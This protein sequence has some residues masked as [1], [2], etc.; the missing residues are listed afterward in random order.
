MRSAL[1]RAAATLGTGLLVMSVATVPA[2][3]EPATLSGIV[4]A[5]DTGLPV[6][7]CVN[8]YDTQY[9]WIESQCTDES[10]RWVTTSTESGAVYKVEIASNDQGYKSEWAVDTDMYEMA[11]EYIAPATVPGVLAAYGTP[12]LSG[13]IT[14]DVTGEPLDGCVTAYR[15]ETAEW[16]G[17]AC[18]GS[19]AAG[20]WKLYD[21]EQGAA[22]RVEVGAW[23]GVH[24]GEWA[25]DAT[26]FDEAVDIVVP[27]VVDTGLKAGARITGTLLGTDGSA[28]VDEPVRVDSADGTNA[29]S[30]TWT[31]QDGTWS[32]SVAPGDYVVSF[33]GTQTTQYAVGALSREDA[34]VFSVAAG[35][36]ADAS[37]RLLPAAS[38]QGVIT[39]AV[40][41]SP[42]G[43]ACV[44]VIE[45]PVRDTPESV[46]EACTD[47][48]GAYSAR[49]SNSGQFIARVEDPQGRFAFEYTGDAA[50]PE[51]AAP[52]EV[53]AGTPTT[54]DAA[55]GLGASISGLA[56]DGKTDVPIDGAC[57][58]PY[59][60]NDGGYA[61]GAVTEC[62][63]TDGRWTVKGLPA[64]GYAL[65]LSTGDK[66]PYV[67]GTWAFKATSQATAELVDVRAGQELAVRNVK[68]APGGVL[69][70]RVTDQFGRPA[71]GV[72]V[73]ALGTFPGR[74]GPGEGL[75]TDST[76]GNGYYRIVG[77][78][79]GE[80]TPLAYSE[81]FYAPEWSGDAD[82]PS[83]AT[84]I[85][86]KAGKT[87]TMDVEVGPAGSLEGEILLSG[88]QEDT[89][90]Y[91]LGQVFTE[92]GTH[93]ADFDSYF[94]GS[95]QTRPLPG[96]EFTIRLQTYHGDKVAW[97]DSATTA[98]DARRVPLQ[99]GEHKQVDIHLP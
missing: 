85:T 98:A 12:S 45:Y 21:L 6:S 17:F 83:E 31:G 74:A 77:L 30:D 99:R 86:V 37:D 69:T 84:P 43:G 7:A 46:A 78:P 60:G 63:G 2:F 10:G 5:A 89:G 73:D 48:T 19:G 28:R 53:L 4:T 95:Y 55:L 36:T 41:G 80:Y 49:L 56:V 3:A 9:N 8:V 27:A 47:E 26:S 87:T 39:S 97:Y 1:R 71:S 52:I 59:V 75:F 15:A 54:F 62:S 33:N 35:E 66:T 88:G 20:Q 57:P 90:E 32:V 93:I 34:T 29:S 76:D 72:W 22:Y 42:V 65:H 68:L 79:A 70:G 58:S 38:V 92:D 18:S 16:A 11:T 13:T 64:G 23:D 91:W 25:Q 40:D 82:Q 44:R 51:A 24:I 96:G 50:T 14:S 94:S 67:A 61:Q 81:Y